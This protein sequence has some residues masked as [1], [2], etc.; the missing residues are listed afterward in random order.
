MKVKYGICIASLC[1]FSYLNI[2]INNGKDIASLYDGVL[3]NSSPIEY[4]LLFFL[5]STYC[6]FVYHEFETYIYQS[7]MYIVTRE[8]SRSKMTLRLC[9]KLLFYILQFE[10]LKLICYILVMLI[11]NKVLV[12]KSPMETLK[13]MLLQCLVYYII[14]LF[15]VLLE[16]VLS[17]NTAL[18]IILSLYSVSIGI[19]DMIFSFFA[20]SKSFLNFIILPNISMKLR[21]DAMDY[22]NY[23]YYVLLGYLLL[24]IFFTYAILRKT[25]AKIDI[26]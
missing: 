11:M 20:N 19:S 26:Y 25:F 6:L 2:S 17:S 4:A 16:I 12:L 8:Q 9:K 13:M 10:G 18:F 23:L 15:Q 14:L 7:G 5:F 22:S 1:L 21:L 3:F 24:I